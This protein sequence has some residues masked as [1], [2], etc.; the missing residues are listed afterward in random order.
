MEKEMR[1]LY[2]EG[3]A[4]N[5][6][7]SHASAAREGGGEALTGVRVGPAIVQ[8][9]EIQPSLLLVVI[10]DLDQH[11]TRLPLPLAA[12][13]LRDRPARQRERYPGGGAE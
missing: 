13:G 10:R 6:R 8:A 1:E 11:A 5:G 2:S 3:L 4:S 7:P 12:V 9:D